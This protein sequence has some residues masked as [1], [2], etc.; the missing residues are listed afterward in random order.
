[1]TLII[2]EFHRPDYFQMTLNNIRFNN[3][4]ILDSKRRK[5]SVGLSIMYFFSVTTFSIS[6]SGTKVPLS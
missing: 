5:E 2:F 1:M 3:I 6:K 4:M